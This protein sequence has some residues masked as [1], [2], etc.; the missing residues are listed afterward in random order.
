VCD[1]RPDSSPSD[2]PNML[3]LATFGDVVDGIL[4]VEAV[5]RSL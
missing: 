4:A 1:H 2:G 3:E 5:V